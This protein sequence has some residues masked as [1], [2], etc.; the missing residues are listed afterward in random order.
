MP[1]E[2]PCVLS[3]AGFD[4]SGG[5]GVLAD[6]KTFEQHKVLGMGAVTGLTFQNDSEFD[7]VKWIETDEIIKQTEV[8]TRKFKFEFIKVGLIK[9]LQTL[10]VVISSLKSLRK[11]SFG[12]VSSLKIIWDPILKAST[13]FEI[14]KAIDK[15][16]IADIYKNIYLITPNTDEIKILTGEIDEMQGAKELSKYCNVL[17][18]GGHREKKKGYDY[19]FT[20]DGK[21]FSF[22][23]KKISEI[24]KHGSGCVLSSAITANLA[25]GN[26]LQ[27]SCLKGKDYVT[28]YLMSSKTLLGYHKS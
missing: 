22:R 16:K 17:L 10:E 18:K 24:G 1:K 19:L 11:E 28:K 21:I 15:K 23:P 2:R 5:A 25:N 27:R 9:D 4:P 14:H 6:I 12:Q 3:I 26:D 20:T 8:L 13:G 7:G